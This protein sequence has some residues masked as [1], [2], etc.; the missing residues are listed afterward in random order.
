MHVHPD[1]NKGD[2]QRA[3]H[4]QEIELSGPSHDALSRVFGSP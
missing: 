4:S 2:D 1:Y 3:Y